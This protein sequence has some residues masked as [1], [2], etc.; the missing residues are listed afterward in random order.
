VTTEYAGDLVSL[1]QP[2][3]YCAGCGA[4]VGSTC[5]R[6]PFC[7]TAIAG[8]RQHDRPPQHRLSALALSIEL[9]RKRAR[10]HRP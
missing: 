1:R 9:R 8:P 2:T 4:F 6:C 10:W 3:E 5:L 7:E